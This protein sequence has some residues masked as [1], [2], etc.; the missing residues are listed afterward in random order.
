MLMVSFSPSNSESL[1]A[2]N[3]FAARASVSGV[4]IS[5]VVVA[6]ARKVS[7]QDK[8]FLFAPARGFSNYSGPERPIVGEKN[9]RFLFPSCAKSL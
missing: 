9:C 8:F 3:D 1:M 2:S 6:M 4:S 5:R 7:N